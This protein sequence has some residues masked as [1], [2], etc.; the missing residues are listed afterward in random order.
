MGGLSFAVANDRLYMF[1]IMNEVWRTLAPN[2]VEGPPIS[3]LSFSFVIL[4]E[5][6]ESKDLRFV[7]P[8]RNRPNRSPHHPRL[9]CLYSPAYPR[10]R[11]H[12]ISSSGHTL[13]CAF[14]TPSPD[15]CPPCWNRCISAGTPAFTS[16]S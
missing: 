14:P 15:P 11:I 6:S 12:L 9:F 4:S 16:A 7:S 13:S 3:L 5:R 10:S 1:V 8:N 2:A